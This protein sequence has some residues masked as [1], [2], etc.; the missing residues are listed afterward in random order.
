MIVVVRVSRRRPIVSLPHSIPK[1]VVQARERLV[2]QQHARVR[3]KRAR[4]RDALA[5]AARQHVR[6]AIGVERETDAIQQRADRAIGLA[7]GAAPEA[8]RHVGGDGQMR[9][10]RVVLEDHAHAS[11]LRLDTHAGALD[12]DTPRS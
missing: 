8:E 4:E 1:P 9:K 12:L 2:H 3:R 7:R 11:L 10:E 5:F 6:I